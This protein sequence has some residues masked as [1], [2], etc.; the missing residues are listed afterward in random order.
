MPFDGSSHTDLHTALPFTREDYFQL[1]D[2]TGRAIRADKKGAISEE[3]PGIVAR[4][5]INPDQWIEHIQCFGRSYGSCVGNVQA[6]A[7]HASKTG[8]RWC[9]GLSHSM[10]CYR[11]AS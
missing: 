3:L 9:K 7:A 6:I 4:L 11:Q 8:K 10:S 5:G 2:A 1:V